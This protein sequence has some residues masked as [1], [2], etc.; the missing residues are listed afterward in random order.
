MAASLPALRLKSCLT[1]SLLQVVEEFSPMA[2]S[3]LLTDPEEQAATAAAVGQGLAAA[4]RQRCRQVSR[5]L[6][7]GHEL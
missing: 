4:Y 7:R 6:P 3:R 1:T 5:R 2:A